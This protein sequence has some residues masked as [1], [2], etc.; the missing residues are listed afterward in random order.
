MKLGYDDTLDCFGIHGVGSGLGV[1]LLSFFIRDSWMASAS[2][3]AGKT[4]TVWNQLLVQL[5]GFGATV[6]LASVLTLLICIFVEKTI[7]FRLDQESEMTGLDKALHC[8]RGY[9]FS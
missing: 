9:D 8:E 1:I 4:W 5:K 7:G 3:S 2:I 6:L